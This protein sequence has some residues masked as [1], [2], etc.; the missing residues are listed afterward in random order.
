GA[1]DDGLDLDFVVPA[2]GKQR[3]DRAIGQAAGE[4]FLFGG[5]AFAF[6]ITP[7][8][9]ARGGG[10]LAII[11]G[12]REEILAF[13]GFGG[14]DRRDENDGFAE[15]DGDGAVGLLC[16]LFGFHDDLFVPD[17]GIYFFWHMLPFP[18]L[19]PRNFSKSRF[20]RD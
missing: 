8:E 1:E 20:D 19:P 13:L 10:L 6:E 14:G 16:E 12:E 3:T 2:F 5:P 15:L 9:L 11:H 7:R 17:G 4:N 18:P